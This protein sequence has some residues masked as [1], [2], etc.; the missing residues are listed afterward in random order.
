MELKP[1][2]YKLSLWLLTFIVEYY[3]SWKFKMCNLRT[4]IAVV[5]RDQIKGQ[6]SSH[7]PSENLFCM[8]MNLVARTKRRTYIEDVWQQV[9]EEYIW[10]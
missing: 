9:A 10:T 6:V 2:W 4:R 1:A 5:T 7:L 8:G 3:C